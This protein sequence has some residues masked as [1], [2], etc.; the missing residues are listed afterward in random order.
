M[1]NFILFVS[2]V[3]G[4]AWNL[5][6]T[7]VPGFAFTYA[8]VVLAVAFGSGALVLVRAFLG[9]GTFSGITS[10]GRSTRNPRISEERKNDTR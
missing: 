3:F 10:Q 6:Q 1:N 5:F 7:P 2:T 8:D 9:L 4:G